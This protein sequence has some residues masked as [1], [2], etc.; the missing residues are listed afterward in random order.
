MNKGNKIM[1]PN[2]HSYVAGSCYYSA[3]MANV[4]NHEGS[5]G[6]IIVLIALLLILCSN[7]IADVVIVESDSPIIQSMSY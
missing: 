5:S 7:S 3:I 1:P 2:P 4:I 6:R